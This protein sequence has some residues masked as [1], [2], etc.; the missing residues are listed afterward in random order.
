MSSEL[1]TCALFAF[2]LFMAVIVDGPAGLTAPAVPVVA[3][4]PEPVEPDVVEPDVVKFEVVEPGV[5]PAATPAFVVLFVDAP[6]VPAVPAVPMV[7]AELP[8]IPIGV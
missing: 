1:N 8:E 4:V 6:A 7:V 3:F 5:V 2:A